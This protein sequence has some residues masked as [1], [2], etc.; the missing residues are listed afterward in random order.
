VC[1]SW[2]RAILGGGRRRGILWFQAP[3]LWHQLGQSALQSA[4][5]HRRVADCL[6]ASPGASFQVVAALPRS[7]DGGR[8]AR[9]R[10]SAASRLRSGGMVGRL[11][12]RARVK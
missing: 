4:F 11:L 7:R 2:R 12:R 6:T 1:S 3:G 9:F 8:L 10:M 5:G